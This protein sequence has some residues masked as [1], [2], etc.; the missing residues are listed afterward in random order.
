M[1]IDFAGVG[2]EL[3]EKAATESSA[4]GLLDEMFPYIYVASKRMSVRAISR[5]LAEEKNIK[6]SHVSLSKA[7]RESE[8]HFT[9]IAEAAS[10]AAGVLAR[11]GKMSEEDILFGEDYFETVVKP[12][13]PFSSAD[14]PEQEVIDAASDLE[15]TWFAYPEEVHEACKRYFTTP[16]EESQDE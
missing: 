3:I 14:I 16:I 5:W 7:L 6:I 8:E 12:H 13:L 4:P 10:L 2:R 1:K 11:A 9:R 15:S